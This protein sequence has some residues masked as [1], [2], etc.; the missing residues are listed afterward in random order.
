M[1]KTL[2]E[3]VNLTGFKPIKNIWKSTYW[4]KGLGA[5]HYLGEF[6]GKKAV[7][8][9]QLVKPKVSEVFM[10]SEFS[11]IN[12]SSLIRPP[13][14]YMTVPWDDKNNFEVII[15]EYVKG[16]Q[17]INDHKLV[18]T[19]DVI[20][21][22]KY[23]KN[24]KSYCIPEISWI[25]KPPKINWQENLEKLYKTSL[26]TFPDSSLRK[27]GDYELAK[28]ASQKLS[29]IYE[30][31][32]LEFMHGHFSC[33]DLVFEDDTKNKVVLFSNLF[34]KWKMPYAD[35]VFAYHWFMF[36]L[37]RIDNITP[38]NID[39]QKNIWL[40]EIYKVSDNKKL[41]DAALLERAVAGLILDGLLMDDKKETSKY[42]M[43]S[44][45][46]RII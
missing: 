9:I 16:Q 38:K 1:N 22:M 34:W 7:L 14:I 32:D 37:A 30:S 20:T 26:E 28:K 21:F 24:Y 19:N 8:K 12:K 17:I 29:K 33:K 36:E 43:D 35:A 31:V 23:Y 39:E 25:E 15:M 2:T 6:K 40:T 45:R 18:T 10:I 41:I 46:E 5:T 42:I 13:K 44:L 4:G 27:D 3:A 11:K